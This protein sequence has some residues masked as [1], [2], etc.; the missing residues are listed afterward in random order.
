MDTNRPDCMRAEEDTAIFR[1]RA[2]S[3]AREAQTQMHQKPRSMS[4]SM[5]ARQIQIGSGLSQVATS[6][7]H[8]SFHSGR[9]RG[10]PLRKTDFHKVARL[11]SIAGA[12]RVNR[13]YLELWRG[14]R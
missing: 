7:E 1:V 4:P 10:I 9:S 3:R 12:V 5:L 13:P 14:I 2:G 8:H 11:T 6:S